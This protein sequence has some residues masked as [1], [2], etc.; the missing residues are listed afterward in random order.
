LNIDV[1]CTVSSLFRRG[2]RP[3]SA[4]ARH[5]LNQNRIGLVNRTGVSIHHVAN[6]ARFCPVAFIFGERRA[7]M[8]NRLCAAS[9]AR[10]IKNFPREPH[11]KSRSRKT[12]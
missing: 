1:L 8:V 11:V 9:S 10:I 5:Q 7:R 2:E 4:L 3:I 6:S 12:S